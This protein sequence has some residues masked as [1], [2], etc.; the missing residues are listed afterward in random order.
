MNR[1]EQGARDGS[2]DREG[3]DRDRPRDRQQRVL[4]FDTAEERV[5]LAT[6]AQDPTQRR[7]LAL[8]LRADEFLESKHK[9]I[10]R[11][12]ARMA[13][14]GL[15][16][17]EDTLRSLA[18]DEDFGGMAYLRKLVEEYRPNVNIEHHV[19][20]FRLDG[21]KFRLLNEHLPQLAE[22]CANPKADQQALASAATA[23]QKVI[24]DRT[25]T[26]FVAEGSALIDRYYETL[27]VRRALGGLFRGTGFRFL[28]KALTLGLAPGK[29]TLVGAR[30]RVGKSLWASQLI[31]N[32][33]RDGVGVLL[34]SWE[35]D[36]VDYLDML[37]SADTGISVVRLTKEIESLTDDERWEVS[38]A[39]E[40]YGP[41]GEIARRGLLAIEESPFGRLEKPK[42]RFADLNERNL[43]HFE[44]TV[45]RECVTKRVV[46][47]DV[48]MKLLPDR[49]PDSVAQALIRVHD[50]ANRYGVHILALH[51]INREGAE[52]PPTLENFK[53]AGA[54]EEEAD[55][56]IGL[57][58]P[59]L[60]ASAAKA[61]KMTDFL[62]VHLLKQ[63]KGVGRHCV[64]YA[65][66][67]AHS[68][69]L[70]EEVVD[71]VELERQQ[72]EGEGTEL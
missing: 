11:G 71:A 6:M 54:F 56:I 55:L 14:E 24:A 31:R 64:R 59:I 4:D 33:I 69:L 68:R 2:R 16:F 44:A 53:G 25:T 50:I 10:F 43:D 39:A 62:D 1:N 30:P 12:F 38:S 7:L 58:R 45:A 48:I 28:D 47:C 60:R 17:N 61:R 52:G 49:R 34:C 3:R 35:M 41:T 46:I 22:L 15:E 13:Q 70:D 18:G 72:V 36:A 8:E 9:V 26:R 29:L 37:V 67:G 23:L 65:F 57:D 51:H 66:D 32:Q 40:R 63:R 27:R 20:R 19:E 5:V 21:A 42:D